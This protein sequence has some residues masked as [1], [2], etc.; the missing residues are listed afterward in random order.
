M[1]PES[2]CQE[3]KNKVF[4]GDKAAKINLNFDLN[5]QEL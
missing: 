2:L 5:I 4:R 1:V 3:F